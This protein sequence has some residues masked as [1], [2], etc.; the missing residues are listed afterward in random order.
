MNKEQETL[1]YLKTYVWDRI[2]HQTMTE[3]ERGWNAAAK[4]VFRKIEQLME[5][6]NHE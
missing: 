5:E 1:E 6:K 2:M 4:E 3:Y